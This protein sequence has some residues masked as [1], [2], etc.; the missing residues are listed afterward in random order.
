MKLVRWEFMGLHMPMMEDGAGELY[1]TSKAIC[2]ALGVDETMLRSTVCRYPKEFSSLSVT[3][4]NAK[5]F[6]RQNRTEF[7][8]VRV[9]NDIRLWSEDDMFSFAFHSKSENSMEYRKR[10]RQFLKQHA[11]RNYVSR[12]EFN[13]IKGE[14]RELKE[15]LAQYTPAANHAASCAGKALRAQ[16]DT[17]PLRLVVN[18]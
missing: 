7:G 11:T 10:L 18:Q 3:N 14:L 8:I 12:E 15:I 4:C 2:E 1:C 17:K 6:L 13:T 5:D 9:R 16:R